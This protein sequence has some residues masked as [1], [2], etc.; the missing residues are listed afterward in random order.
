[1][2]LTLVEVALKVARVD[3]SVQTWGASLAEVDV[4]AAGEGTW[5]RQEDAVIQ[6]AGTEACVVGNAKEAVATVDEGGWEDE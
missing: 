5:R 6:S 1:L 2:Q 3:T 4:A